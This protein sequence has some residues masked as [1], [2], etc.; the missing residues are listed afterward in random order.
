MK[1]LQVA[2][3]ELEDLLLSHPRIV[4]AAVIGVPDEDAGELPRAYVV[5]A[6]HNLSETEV[7]E[8]VKGLPFV[9]HGTSVRV[10]QYKFLRGGIRFVS[11]VPKSAA[12]KI[13]RRFLREEA[14]KEFASKL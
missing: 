9:P 13:L 10:S 1:G 6:D 5:R 7:D 8:F 14:K 3:A 4:D 2:P 12:G 11:E